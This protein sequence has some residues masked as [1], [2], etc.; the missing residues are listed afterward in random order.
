MK[1]SFNDLSPERSSR[2][3]NFLVIKDNIIELGDRKP[4]EWHAIVE[5]MKPYYVGKTLKFEVLLDIREEFDGRRLIPGTLRDFL[6]K[7]ADVVTEE[8]NSR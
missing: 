1:L 5:K 7:L 2:L 4:F 6:K 3:L 8:T